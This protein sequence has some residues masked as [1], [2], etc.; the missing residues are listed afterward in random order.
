MRRLQPLQSVIKLPQRLFIDLRALGIGNYVGAP[1][2]RWSARS[3][4][5]TVGV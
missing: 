2:E 3:T 4:I 1:A 5:G